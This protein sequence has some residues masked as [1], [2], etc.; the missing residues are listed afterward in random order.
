MY[1]AH[2]LYNLTV[3]QDREKNALK[4][5]LILNIFIVLFFIIF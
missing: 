5:F 1:Y 4:P 3:I 2:L